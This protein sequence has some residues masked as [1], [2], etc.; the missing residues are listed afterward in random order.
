MA[1]LRGAGLVTSSR[2]GWEVC[3]QLADDHV[4]HIARDAIRHVQEKRP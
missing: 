1:G 4:A 3:Y 2:R